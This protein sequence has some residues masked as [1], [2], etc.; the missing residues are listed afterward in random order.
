M[1]SFINNT[2]NTPIR[3][4][5]KLPAILAIPSNIYPKTKNDDSDYFSFT[6][7][8]NNTLPLWRSLKICYEPTRYGL[9][10]PYIALLSIVQ[11]NICKLLSYNK[12]LQSLKAHL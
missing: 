2:Y 10:A 12:A 8:D 3:E 6:S 1:R 5:E 11:S 4:K 7:S 9:V